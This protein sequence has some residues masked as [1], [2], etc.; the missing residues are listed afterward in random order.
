MKY[1]EILFWLVF[2]SFFSGSVNSQEGFNFYGNVENNINFFRRDSLIGAFGIPQYNSNDIG[3]EIWIDLHANYKGYQAGIRLDAFR[4]SNLLNPTGS[5]SAE[6]LGRFYLKKDFGK[7]GVELGYLY[8]QIGSGIIFRSY[9]SRAQLLDYALIGAKGSWNISDNITVNGYYGRQKRQFDWYDSYIRGLNFDG[10]FELGKSKSLSLSPGIG[11]INRVLSEDNMDQ[12]VNVLRTYLDEDRSIPKYNA[13]LLSLYNTLAYKS[14]SWYIEGAYKTPELY[15]DPNATRTELT[16]RRVFGKY[17]KNAGTVFYSSLG[18]A[19]KNLGITIEGKRTANF[20]FR[21]DPLLRQNQ[22]LISF[23]PPMNRQNTYR[24][25]SR[26]NPATQD[27]SEI[28]WQMDIKHRLNNAWNWEFNLSDIYTLD[29]NPLFREFYIAFQYKRKR[30]WELKSGIQIM[31]YNQ[32]I[33]E[34]KPEVPILEAKTVFAD[35]LYRIDSKNSIRSEFQYMHTEEDYGQWLF[36]S[37]EASIGRHI[38]LEASGMYNV[39]PGPASPVDPDTGIKKQILYPTLGMQ[40]RWGSR[41][42]NFRYVKQVEG[43][44][45]TGGICR[46]EPA[47]SG[48]RINS[49]AQF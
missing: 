9:E 25:L 47:F 21:T 35:F 46:L 17:V 4:N 33:Y 24:L 12:I 32:E 18:I 27:L 16:G 11:Y 48:F 7:V 23:I 42:I 41:R 10:Y 49:Y 37:V 20:N 26:Y 44:I 36:G 6:G 43:V 40:L 19:V 34:V 38:I 1:Q 22:G 28:A 45:C 39:S 15:Y 29:S 31:S 5:Y 30:K 14:V 8:D 2:F 13:Y 3:G